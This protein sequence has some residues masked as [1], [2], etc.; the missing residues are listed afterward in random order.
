M[1]T[2]PRRPSGSTFAKAGVPLVAMVLGCTYFLTQFLQ[3]HM[4]IKDKRSGKSSSQRKFDLDEEHR[5]L[6][7]KLDIENFSL[8]RI[9][10]PE[11]EI[12]GSKTKGK[13]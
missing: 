2:G 5:L 11:E 4:E 3:T 7:K 12:K 8:S 6:M 9:P 1:K 10:R 13:P